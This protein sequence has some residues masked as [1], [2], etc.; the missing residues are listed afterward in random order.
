VGEE[1]HHVLWARAAIR[2]VRTPTGWIHVH[3][4]AT[5]SGWL[6]QFDNQGRL[7]E[8]QQVWW[9]EER[10]PS[11]LDVDLASGLA[12]LGLEREDADTVTAGLRSDVEPL[13]SP[14]ASHLDALRFYLTFFPLVLGGW[15]LA[16]ALLTWVLVTRV[17]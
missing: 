14:P 4:A 7:V 12:S 13:R 15:A 17:L 9:D 8:T 1:P 10:H 3:L 16:L 6:N 11:F 2:L 5:G